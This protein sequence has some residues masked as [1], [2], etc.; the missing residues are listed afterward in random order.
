MF[1]NLTQK[2]E[3]FPR[4]S[5]LEIIYQGKIQKKLT[6]SKFPGSLSHKVHQIGRM[7]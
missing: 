7:L 3:Y 4:N 1:E 5:F 6:R 2:Q